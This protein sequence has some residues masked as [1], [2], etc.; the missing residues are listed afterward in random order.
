[1]AHKQSDHMARS[2]FQYLAIFNKEN[3]P[4]SI[5]ISQSWF[6][7]LPKTNKTL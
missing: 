5:K 2:F 7:I 4:N 6:K 1:M 3:L